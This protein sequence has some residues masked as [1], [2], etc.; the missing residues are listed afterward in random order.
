MQFIDIDL[1]R[2][3][4]GDIA[5]VVLSAGANVR[6]M[7]QSNFSRYRNGQE[8]RYHGG[9][10]R[11]S[12]VRLAIPSSGYWHVAV[13][14]QGLRGSVRA[15]GRRIPNQLLQ[16][17]PP[18]REH[19]P[20]LRNIADNIAA[21]MPDLLAAERDFDVFVSHASEDKDE[22]VRP[23]A[24]ALRRRGLDVWFDEFELKIGDS[25]RRKI[26][27]GIARSRFGIVVLSPSFFAKGWPQYELDGL[28]TM[29]V[30]G[31]QVLLPL[32]HGISK[33]EVKRQSPSLADKVA[34]RTA[35]Y[36]IEEIA[37]EITSV[38]QSG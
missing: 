9:L 14:M 26:D 28:V 12:P 31:S 23:L 5:E 13:D 4:R 8:H 27:T 20:T 22:I 16:P 29:S 2:C 37:A 7:D 11:Q 15:N 18:I 30:S 24:E 35:D 21:A 1:G 6:L 38:I 10:A 36:T 3:G 34:L 25:L 33:D 17:L 32:W 19:R